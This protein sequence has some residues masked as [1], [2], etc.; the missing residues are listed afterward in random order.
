MVRVDGAKSAHTSIRTV[1]RG[2]TGSMKRRMRI[3]CIKS[4]FLSSSTR[5]DRKRCTDVGC[6]PEVGLVNLLGRLV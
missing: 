4:S 1:C 6:R 3:D 2:A 5:V